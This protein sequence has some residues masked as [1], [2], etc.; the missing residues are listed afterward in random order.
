MKLSSPKQP[1]FLIA[2]AIAILAVVLVLVPT[3][4]A[5]LATH[6]FWILLVAFVILMMGNLLR[7][8]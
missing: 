4:I 6:A 8:F 5:G 1:V 7:D 3:L 2:V